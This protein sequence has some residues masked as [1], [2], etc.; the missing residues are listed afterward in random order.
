[1]NE[2]I[3]TLRYLQDFRCIGPDCPDT[4]C[5]GWKV[6]ID[7]PSFLRLQKQLKR[8]SSGAQQRVKKGLRRQRSGQ[9]RLNFAKTRL[10]KDGRCV[11]LDEDDLCHVL[12]EYGDDCLSETCTFY[13]RVFSVSEGQMTMGA[14]LSCPET[15]RLCLTGQ[16]AVDVVTLDADGLVGRAPLNVSD[17]DRRG[18]MPRYRYAGL[19]TTILGQ[20]LDLDE[21]PISS[22]LFFICRLAE[23]LTDAYQESDAE[24]RL[25]SGIESMADPALLA[26]LN[27]EFVKIETDPKV[28]IALMQTVLFSR[29]NGKQGGRL[30]SLL[31]D[32]VDVYSTR[33]GE[34]LENWGDET[35]ENAA[36]M[37]QEFSLLKD[38][39]MRQFPQLLDGHAVRFCKN[40]LY[41]RHMADYPNPLFFAISM[42]VSLQLSRFLMFG[43]P[44]MVQAMENDLAATDKVAAEQLVQEVGVDVVQRLFRDLE[45]NRDVAAMIEQQLTE[46]GLISLAFAAYL[47]ST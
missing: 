13:P 25:L 35:D 22:R 29:I 46:R 16:N 4:C 40:Y 37:A 6:T 27:S 32:I 15:A 44:R 7:E 1:M 42:L 47:T 12:K 33:I 24:T 31:L 45:H 17:F 38:Y 36:K 18:D 41:F 23:L 39:W 34:P 11:F 8:A 3:K 43:H 20:F 14:T 2:T 10:D 30:K 19:L 9:N 21:F 28:A 5:V 26:Q